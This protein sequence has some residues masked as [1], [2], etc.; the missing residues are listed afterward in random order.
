MA[1]Q[2]ELNVSVPKDYIS[3]KFTII[4]SKEGDFTVTVISPDGQE[5]PAA[6]PAG[7]K[8][9]MACIV[10]NVKAGDWT[11]RVAA[12]DAEPAG[13]GEVIFADDGTPIIT[14][15]GQAAPATPD[16]AIGNVSVRFEGSYEELMEVD[17][18]I[19]IAA[20]IAG[21]SMY[22][23]DDSFVAEW[24]DTTCGDV[25]IEVSD[26][27]TMQK[28]DTAT[29]RE[30]KY[31]CEIS[32]HE[33]PQI[34]VTIVP[35]VSSGIEG[36]QKTY[37]FSSSNHPDATVEFDD[38]SIT[39]K[40]TLNA[41]LDLRQ[42]YS[43]QI[44]VNGK[45][46]SKTE[47][48]DP[49]QFTLPIPID[50]GMNNVLVYIVDPENGYM[51]STSKVVE[52]DVVPPILK[53]AENYDN[54]TTTDESIIFEG[55]VE[56]G[57]KELKINDVQI[58]VE[59]DHTFKYEYK[60]KEG[61]NNI[62]IILDDE[63][64]NVSEYDAMITRM[65]PEKSPVPWKPILVGG[66][67][68]VLAGVAVYAK[69]ILPRQQRKRRKKKKTKRKGRTGGQYRDSSKNV[70]K[71]MSRQ[72]EKEEYDDYEQ[73]DEEDEP[74]RMPAKRSIIGSIIEILKPV[75]NPE[76]NNEDDPDR[77]PV[78]VPREILIKETMWDIIGA[79]IP[80]VT[81]IILL[82]CVICIATVPTK[83]MEPY[84]MAGNTV[85]YNRLAYKRHTVK[86]G[87]IINFK[88]R[89]MGIN[90]TKRVIG[91]AGDE[92]SFRD[93][94]VVLNGQIAD[95]SDYLDDSVETNSKHTFKVPERCVFVL[96]DNREGSK[97]SRYFENPYISEKDIIGK[98][99]GQIDFSLAAD[100]I[101][102]LVARFTSVVSDE[103]TDPGIALSGN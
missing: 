38:V 80:V 86:R 85:F 61:V 70:K 28:I 103:K 24:T 21:L 12:P 96:G 77:I 2:K 84:I 46:I 23:K 33:H 17:K 9:D 53:L 16:E 78:T 89:E 87:D 65:I 54:V 58:E 50:D 59:G 5:Y 56:P 69:V 29:V 82:T 79:S 13:G 101:E 31:E 3:A 36:A 11:V 57:Y 47:V 67:I 39:N 22:F 98:Y 91:I 26:S 95:E 1:A 7:E 81:V 27:K 32:E 94:Y 41:Y 97:D 37:T 88:S 68:I 90:E 30:K 60:L 34:I 102:P 25:N 6:H 18:D 100:V 42:K 92:I 15:D 63:A 20:N 83:S 52:L 43:A 71:N 44:M 48:M 55:T 73:E 45:Q 4:L 66:F 51:R 35:A 62:S 14:G 74:I 8:K 93:G 99:I 72:R 75:P 10:Q 49:G 64:G 76:N 40:G 19:K